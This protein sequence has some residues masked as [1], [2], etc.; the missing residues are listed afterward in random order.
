MKESKKAG[1][2][3]TEMSQL[4]LPNDTNLLG[5]LLGGQLMHWIDIV[6]AMVASRHSNQKVATVSMDGLEF[7]HPIRQGELVLLKATLI[8]VGNTSMQV[9]VEVYAE[10]MLSGK[11]MLTNVAKITF[12]ALD[13]NERPTKVPKLEIETS[14]QQERFDRAQ[15]RHDKIKKKRE[16]SNDNN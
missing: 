5:N 16:V 14:L 15:V 10:N 12:V 3:Y 4:V 11:Q 2:S 1:E 8:W 9:A 13:D 6:G 7:R